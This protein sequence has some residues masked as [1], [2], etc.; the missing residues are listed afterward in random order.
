LYDG[1]GKKSSPVLP[2]SLPPLGFIS[3]PDTLPQIDSA[4]SSAPPAFAVALPGVQAVAPRRPRKD[5]NSSRGEPFDLLG[6][7]VEKEAGMFIQ[8]ILSF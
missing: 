8:E 7:G 1:A 5:K 2:F 4:F 3:V 6:A